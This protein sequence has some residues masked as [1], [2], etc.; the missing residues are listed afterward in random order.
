[1]DRWKEQLQNAL[2]AG[3]YT[4]VEVAGDYITGEITWVGIKGFEINIDGRHTRY[5][6]ADVFCVVVGEPIRGG[7]SVAIV[8]SDVMV[9]L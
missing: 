7:T 3:P 1:M 6:I 4:T 8:T 5:N 2:T 9:G